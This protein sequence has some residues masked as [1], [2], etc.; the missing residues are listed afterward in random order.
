MPDFISSSI[1]N[2]NNLPENYQ[3]SN[4]PSV[5]PNI[6]PSITPSITPNIAPNIAP[7]ITQDIT[8]S[9][10]QPQSEDIQF[11]SQSEFPHPSLSSCMCSLCCALFILTSILNIR[12][13]FFNGVSIRF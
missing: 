13:S 5:T 1:T 8:Y 10:N 12:N 4:I 3:S 11:Q 7:S 9:L 6:A 2:N